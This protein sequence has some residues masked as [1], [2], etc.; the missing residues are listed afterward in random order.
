[1]WRWIMCPVIHTRGRS[2]LC[3]RLGTGA[4]GARLGVGSRP[5][6]LFLGGLRPARTSVCSWHVLAARAPA[7]PGAVLLIAGAGPLRASVPPRGRRARPRRFS[8]LPGRVAGAEKVRF[9]QIADLFVFPSSLEGFGLSVAEAMSCGL[10]VLV[11]NRARCPGDRG[12]VESRGLR[13]RQAA[14]ARQWPA[15]CA[16]KSGARRA[17]RAPGGIDALFRWDRAVSRF[18]EFTET[19]SR[20]QG[21]PAHAVS[22]VIRTS[23]ARDGSVAGARAE[24]LSA[25][26]DLAA[27]VTRA[28][29]DRGH[30]LRSGGGQAGPPA[31]V[32]DAPRGRGRLLQA[33][34]VCQTT[35]GC[36]DSTC[37][38]A[39][40]GR[41]GSRARGAGRSRFPFAQF[42]F[43]TD[44]WHL[45]I[46]HESFMH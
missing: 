29:C 44:R 12:R 8:D 15:S 24:A 30:P 1:M 5:T 39:W 25:R 23:E 43:R 18:G 38:A 26:P 2:A 40:H 16:L 28:R 42:R 34:R 20:W 45:V 46:C 4:G 6:T 27:L 36:S 10:P 22:D 9:Y 19:L 11:A 33:A 21:A 37:N 31:P 3:P 32:L 17:D 13:S 41:R 7:V 14:R 35:C